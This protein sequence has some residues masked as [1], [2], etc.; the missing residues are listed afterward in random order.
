MSSIFDF[1]P[2][3]T[4]K[5]LKVGIIGGT[6]LEKSEFM[7]PTGT[8]KVATP[9]GDPS[10]EFITGTFDGVEVVVLA[11]HGRDHRL[12]PTNVN[13][14]ANLW[15][16]K[17]L[18]V[19]IVL[20]SNASGS[21]REEIAPGSFV[22]P[23]SFIDWT[24][25]RQRTYYDGQQGHPT[26]VCHI[27]CFPSYSEPLRKILH[28]CASEIGVKSHDGTIICI[29]G[30]RFSS[31]AESMMFR[32]MGA[33]VI[34]MTACPEVYLAKELGLLYAAVALVTDYDCWRINDTEFVTVEHVKQ[35]ML[36][37]AENTTKL[38][39]KAIKQIKANE[40]ILLGEVQAAEIIADTSI[41]R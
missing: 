4:T 40:E 29:E 19:S 24:H 17:S 34:N 3:T 32:Q 15:A 38:F 23:N 12:N 35:V 13:F 31:R 1:L 27:P 10:D 36:K 7:V 28:A 5:P 6:G 8:K 26:G 37:N 21:L 39:A 2:K 22:V 25:Q 11:R 30:P 16:M 14:R 18:G 33:D 20:A 9:Y 41:M